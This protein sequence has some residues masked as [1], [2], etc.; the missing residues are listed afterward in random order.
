VVVFAASR[1]AMIVHVD[2]GYPHAWRKYQEYFVGIAEKLPVFLVIG[3]KRMGLGPKAYELAN[4][5]EMVIS[6]KVAL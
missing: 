2:P 4:A 6:E 1:D 5:A 3:N